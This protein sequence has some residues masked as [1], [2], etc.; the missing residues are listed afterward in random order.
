MYVT[1]HAAY[2]KQM[3]VWATE[4]ENGAEPDSP[5]MPWPLRL[6]LTC[7]LYHCMLVAGGLEDQPR[8]KWLQMQVA[9]DAYE[10]A[11]LMLQEIERAKQVA[12]DRLDETRASPPR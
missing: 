11:Q 2:E 3:R 1:D 10:E 4:D 7:R 8:W 9:G 6:F 5:T 12:L